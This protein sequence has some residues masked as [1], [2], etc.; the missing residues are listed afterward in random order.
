[1]PFTVFDTAHN[2]RI[3]ATT[4]VQPSADATRWRRRLRKFPS[5]SSQRGLTTYLVTSQPN[6]PRRGLRLPFRLTSVAP[7]VRDE[8][9]N[10]SVAVRTLK[11][12]L[13]SCS[14]VIRCRSGSRE[15]RSSVVTRSQPTLTGNSA[16]TW[17]PLRSTTV[18]QVGVHSYVL[19]G[20]RHYTSPPGQE[21]CA[22][23]CDPARDHRCPGPHPQSGRLPSFAHLTS[24]PR[25]TF[26]T[27][28]TRCSKI[29]VEYTLALPA[30]RAVHR[31]GG[32]RGCANSRGVESSVHR[33][34]ARSAP[35]GLFP[36]ASTAPA[37]HLWVETKDCSWLMCVDSPSLALYR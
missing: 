30:Q 22:Q 34:D 5:I 29:T 24:Y 36:A 15:T 9:S 35:R 12:G 17:L 16:T 11:N 7:P 32:L 20:E 3:T 13:R 8:S 31:G 37:Q 23:H 28:C 4:C 18:G 21:Q 33:D 19:L 10:T 27:R 25:M 6:R 14:K 26:W 2:K 1:M